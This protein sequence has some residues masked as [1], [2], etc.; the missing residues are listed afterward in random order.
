MKLHLAL[1]PEDYKDS[2]MPYSDAGDKATYADIPFVFKV[3]SGL[4]LRRAKGLIADVCAQDN[5]IQDDIMS[6]DWVKEINANK[7]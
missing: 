4:S 7:E 5:L 1:N 2:K 6:I 3:K